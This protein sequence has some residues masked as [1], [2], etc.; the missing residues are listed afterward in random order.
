[1]VKIK[2]VICSRE[3]RPHAKD[4]ELGNRIWNL[5]HLSSVW[6]SFVIMIQGSPLYYLLIY[7][8]SVS[9]AI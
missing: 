3:Q 2:V 8:S 7:P 6:L 1:M 9:E 4:K 5:V